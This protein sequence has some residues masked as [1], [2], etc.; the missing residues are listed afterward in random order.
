ME[1][2]LGAPQPL[3]HWLGAAQDT[4]T[5]ARPKRKLVPSTRLPAGE[6]ALSAKLEHARQNSKKA[7]VPRAGRSGKGGKAA[8]AKQRGGGSNEEVKNDTMDEVVTRWEV[9]EGVVPEAW[10]GTFKVI[11]NMM[12]SGMNGRPASEKRRG[13]S[14]RRGR[15][16]RGTV[17]GLRCT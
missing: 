14:R 5:E 2:L 16:G 15:G 10:D 6:E 11:N 9:P 4:A 7:V 17:T 1:L 13:R 8:T 12:G 3:R